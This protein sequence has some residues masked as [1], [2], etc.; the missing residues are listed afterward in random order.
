MAAARVQ[1]P[2][3]GFLQR[4]QR[5]LTPGPFTWVAKSGPVK[6]R[7][8]PGA[9]MHGLEEH[10]VKDRPAEFKGTGILEVPR[11]WGQDPPAR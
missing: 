2:S 9:H 10:D 7:F 4:L 6:H 8:H 5:L 3:E 11:G 1:T